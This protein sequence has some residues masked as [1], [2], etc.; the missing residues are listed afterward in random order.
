MLQSI[1]ILKMSPRF[2]Y[3]AIR[4]GGLA[5]AIREIYQVPAS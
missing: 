3:V 2:I 4:M 5:T 1:V